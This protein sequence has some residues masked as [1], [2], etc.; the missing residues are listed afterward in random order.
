MVIIDYL[1]DVMKTKLV[2]LHPKDK[3]SKAK[4]IFQKY[5]LHHIPIVVNKKLVGILSMGDLLAYKENKSSHPSN[6]R[7][8]LVYDLDLKTV[9]EIMTAD[10]ITGKSN[11]SISEAIDIMLE[12][13]VNALP[14]CENNQLVG[15]ITTYD[16]LKLLKYKIETDH[17]K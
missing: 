5:N 12:Q 10:P 2:T 9:D 13:R 7:F 15:M 1:S 8:Q 16:M 14:I 11:Y 4:Q 17:V 6:D 3:I